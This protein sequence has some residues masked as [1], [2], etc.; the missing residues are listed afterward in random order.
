MSAPRFTIRR[1]DRSAFDFFAGT[2]GVVDSGS[3][4]D[5][6]EGIFSLCRERLRDLI[7]VIQRE[8]QND[9]AESWHQDRQHAMSVDWR[10]RNPPAGVAKYAEAVALVE[11]EVIAKFSGELRHHAISGTSEDAHNLNKFKTIHLQSCYT[12]VLAINTQA[13]TI[14][15]FIDSAIEFSRTSHVYSSIRVVKYYI[16]KGGLPNEHLDRPS[17]LSARLPDMAALAL[18]FAACASFAR[19]DLMG[20]ALALAVGVINA[21]ASG[22]ARI[23]GWVS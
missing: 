18:T 15:I 6:S 10:G 13:G 22:I 8:L 3:A 7:G 9:P 14:S 11:G 20:S 23:A 21:V 5:F 2:G 17:L 16:E 1:N 19:A 4:C 12:S